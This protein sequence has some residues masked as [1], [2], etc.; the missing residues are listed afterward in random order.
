[1]VPEFGGKSALSYIRQCVGHPR[2]V[3]SFHRLPATLAGAFRHQDGGRCRANG[4]GSL[5]ALVASGAAGGERPF[6]RIR[7]RGWARLRFPER[8]REGV[9]GLGAGRDGSETCPAAAGGGSGPRP[10]RP[11][12]S[13]RP[14]PVPRPSPASLGRLFFCLCRRL[15]SASS[16][17]P[18][19][20]PLLQ[21][22]RAAFWSLNSPPPRLSP[23]PRLLLL[24]RKTWR[25]L[26]VLQW[27]LK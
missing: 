7:A 9:R 14:R 19:L 8:K 17:L 10:A 16:L 20:P 22:A 11:I 3:R 12:P 4:R 18:S 1:M 24:A 27:L 5:L 13:P 15:F 26:R 23:R 21:T 6:R 2:W 25:S